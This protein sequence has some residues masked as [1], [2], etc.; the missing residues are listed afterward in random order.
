MYEDL[1]FERLLGEEGFFARLLGRSP[2]GASLKPLYGPDPPVVL[3][4]GGPGMGKGRLLRVVHNRFALQVPVIRL[5]C[6][7]PVYAHR[8]GAEPGARSAAT[9]ALYVGAH[10]RTISQRASLWGV[11]S[12][13]GHL[14]YATLGIAPN[15]AKMK[16]F[17]LALEGRITRQLDRTR[18]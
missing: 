15:A 17:Q 4:T 14:V 8:A 18:R 11:S 10:P 3:L 16:R 2:S 7:S 6:A 12:R 5:N 1:G 13:V 9:E